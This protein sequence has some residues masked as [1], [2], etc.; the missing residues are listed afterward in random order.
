[1][2]KYIQVYDNVIDELSCTEL[3]NKFEDSY[4]TF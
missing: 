4:E 3:V 2:D 1:M